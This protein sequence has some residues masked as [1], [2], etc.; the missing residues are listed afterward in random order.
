MDNF[1]VNVNGL[2]I[3]Y[4]GEAG[5]TLLTLLHENKLTAAKLG[6]GT[7]HCGACTVWLE[8]QV[9]RSC[10]TPLWQVADSAKMVVTLEG[11]QAIE[12]MLSR[13]L[14]SAFIEEQAAQCGYCSAGILMRAAHLIRSTS[15]LNSE[16]IAQALDEHLCRCG[17]HQ[18]VVNAVLNAAGKYSEQ[19]SQNSC[20]A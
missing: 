7:G 14:I 5:D 1:A 11:L 19:Q 8:G 10:E 3:P 12:P 2:S 9:V 4:Q 16:L 18:R 17:S 20:S 15:S 13:A 6:C